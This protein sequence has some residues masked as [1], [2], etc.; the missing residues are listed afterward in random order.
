VYVYLIAIVLKKS[1]CTND[2]YLLD[3][4]CLEEIMVYKWCILTWL[5]LSWRNHG[6]D[7]DA[8]L[9]RNLSL[10]NHGVDDVICDC[11]NCVEEFWCKWWCTH[12]GNSH[13]QCSRHRSQT[14]ALRSLNGSSLALQTWPM[15]AWS[16]PHL[17]LQDVPEPEWTSDLQNLVMRKSWKAPQDLQVTSSCHGS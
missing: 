13:P 17:E 1:W 7:D 5:Q 14:C 9:D 2:A 3:C 15:F 10:K 12:D 16:F 4:N 8:I 11:M 6:V